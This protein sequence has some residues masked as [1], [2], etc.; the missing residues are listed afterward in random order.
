[1]KIPPNI[2]DTWMHRTYNNS[3]L[4][5]AEHGDYFVSITPGGLYKSYYVVAVLGNEKGCTEIRRA[6]AICRIHAI[7][8]TRY[9]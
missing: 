9:T 4:V 6:A 1:M 2:I 8:M 3:V 7:A 5:K